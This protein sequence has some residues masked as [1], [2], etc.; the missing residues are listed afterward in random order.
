MT[1]LPCVFSSNRA[2]GILSMFFVFGS[3]AFQA[4]HS[5][6]EDHFINV[7]LRLWVPDPDSRRRIYTPEA[8]FWPSEHWPSQITLRPLHIAVSLASEFVQKLAD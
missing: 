6:S 3:Q 4:V 1:N 5:G 2:N 8:A 7:I